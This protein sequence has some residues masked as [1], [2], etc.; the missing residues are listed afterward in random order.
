ML[1]VNQSVHWLPVTAKVQT[2][3]YLTGTIC[4]RSLRKHTDSP[5]KT[6]AC[7]HTHTHTHTGKHQLATNVLPKA[8]VDL[9]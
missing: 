1:T 4:A 7:L 8:K 5:D 6:H 2:C 3:Q 9:S